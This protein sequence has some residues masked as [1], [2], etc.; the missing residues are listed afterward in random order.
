VAALNA[1]GIV[2]TLVATLT[3][4]SEYCVAAAA[5]CLGYVASEP[6]VMEA[7]GAVLGLV[8]VIQRLARPSDLDKESG[9]FCRYPPEHVCRLCLFVPVSECVC[10]C[11]CSLCWW[12]S[13]RWCYRHCACLR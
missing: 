12:L 8:K 4:K 1:A 11:V 7:S 13:I 10:V 9:L 2:H 3:H 5:A 6:S